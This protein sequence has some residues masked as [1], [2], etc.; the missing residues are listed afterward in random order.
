M[1]PFILSEC[2]TIHYKTPRG[3]H[4]QSII[5]CKASRTGAGN[6][7]HIRIKRRIEW[8]AYC[9][10]QERGGPHCFLLF[11]LPT[12]FLKFEHPVSLFTLWRTW[13]G[14]LNFRNYEFFKAMEDW[15]HVFLLQHFDVDL[16]NKEV[17]NNIVHLKAG[18]VCHKQRGLQWSVD[19]YILLPHFKCWLIT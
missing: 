3:K 17:G 16:A 9:P 1:D 7:S 6:L 19:N 11:L 8:Q 13:C 2:K 5:W 14:A 12:W 18:R 4:R 10:D 15:F